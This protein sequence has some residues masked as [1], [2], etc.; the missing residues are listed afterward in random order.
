MVI[1]RGSN[2]PNFINHAS[3]VYMQNKIYIFGGS[4]GA[5]ENNNIYT[6]DLD[7]HRWN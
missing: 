4:N 2:G 7:D 5:V 1:T 3:G 6:L